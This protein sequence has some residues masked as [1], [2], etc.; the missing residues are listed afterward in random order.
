MPDSLPRPGGVVPSSAGAIRRVGQ[1][2]RCR[3][4]STTM[5]TA[6]A[7]AWSE[8]RNVRRSAAMPSAWAASPGTSA[9]IP[10]SRRTSGIRPPGR[11]SPHLAGA[12]HPRRLSGRVP[13][14]S[15]PAAPP[16]VSG[17]VRAG[18]VGSDESND[19]GNAG[20]TQLTGPGGVGTLVIFSTGHARLPPPMPFALRLPGRTGRHHDFAGALHSTQTRHRCL[21]AP[22]VAEQRI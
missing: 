13:R 17:T 7:V 1:C 11:A 18:A 19:D 6:T 15:F 22:S 20:M 9:T 21:P 5:P 10:R 12:G 2:R 14:R 16:V 3:M 4:Q 8:R